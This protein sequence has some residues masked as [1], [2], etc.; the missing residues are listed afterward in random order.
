VAFAVL[1]NQSCGFLIGEIL[2]PLVGPEME[3]DPDAFVRR[4]DHREGVAAEEVHMAEAP[5]DAAV[6]HGDRDLVQR[7]WQ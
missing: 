7:V 2:D 6:R 3:F 5:R 4:I 1:G